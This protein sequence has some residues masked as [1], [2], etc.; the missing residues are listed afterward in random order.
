MVTKRVLIS[1]N[2]LLGARGLGIGIGISDER[3]GHQVAFFH[4][5]EKKYLL[6][7]SLSKLF[8]VITQLLWRI[9]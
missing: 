3:N 1:K 5:L 8:N 2:T 7:Y 6:L 9:S 4:L